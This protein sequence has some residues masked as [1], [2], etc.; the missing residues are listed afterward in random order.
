MT[1]GA[2]ENGDE[3][4]FESGGGADG[5]DPVCKLHLIE[6]PPTSAANCRR[7]GIGRSVAA[8]RVDDGK[9][10]SS[11]SASRY[12]G[13]GNGALLVAALEGKYKSRSWASMYWGCC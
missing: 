1:R 2:D 4:A 11:S 8:R 6:P 10:A 7:A 5:D 13:C 9:Y 12:E 3:K